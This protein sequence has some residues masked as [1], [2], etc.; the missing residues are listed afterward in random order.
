MNVPGIRSLTGQWIILI[1]LALATS[2]VVYFYLYR[3]EQARATLEMRRDDF[4]ARAASIGRLVDIVEPHLQEKIVRAAKS[5]SMRYWIT[6][7]FP[8]DTAEWQKVAREKLQEH[9][10]PPAGAVMD[11][12]PEAAW[13]LIEEDNRFPSGEV[14][15]LDLSAWKGFGLVRKVN[16]GLWMNVVYAKPGVVTGPPRLHYLFLGITAALLLIVSIWLATRTGGPL[17]RL[18]EAAEKLGRGEQIPP[19]PEEGPEDIRRLASAFNRMQGR[20]RRFVEDRTGMIAAISHDLRTPIT[21]MRLRAEFIEDEDIRR[22][23]VETL[24]EMKAISEAT[25]AFSREEATTEPTRQID[26]N[27]LLGSLCA[28][29]SELGWPVEFTEGDRLVRRCR[30]DA[31]KRAFGN[32]IE[33]AVRYGTRAKVRTASSGD[34]AEII[35][36]DDGPGIPEN[37]RERVFDPFVRLEHSRNRNTGGTGLGLSI[38]RTILRNHGGDVLL[39][40][41][42]RGLRVTLSLPK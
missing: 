37:D 4:L 36:E 8:A 28:D 17:R 30:P 32:V 9:P 11:I 26:I 10:G 31:L 38:A 34:A 29:L 1:L 35:I 15:T 27:A 6:T 23:I 2:N 12:N 19:V 39:S 25:L 20:L 13:E 14:S 33:N 7:E 21:T 42:T 24:D 16:D 5:T 3:A 40:N 22:K 18:T 41:L